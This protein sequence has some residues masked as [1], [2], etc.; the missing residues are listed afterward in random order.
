MG[1]GIMHGKRQCQFNL[2]HLLSLFRMNLRVN[3]LYQ[4]DNNSELRS[5]W[6]WQCSRK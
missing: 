5:H 2:D 3:V 6:H 4:G 1:S